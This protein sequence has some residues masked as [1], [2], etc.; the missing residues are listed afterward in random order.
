MPAAAEPADL[1]RRVQ[2]G[3]RLPTR[4]ENAAVEVGVK[5]AERLAGQHMQAD[6]DQRTRFRVEEP[7]R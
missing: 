2:P 3:H 1:A 5:A 7:V 6:G 4:G